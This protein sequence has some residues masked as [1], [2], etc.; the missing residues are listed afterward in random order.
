MGIGDTVWLVGHTFAEGF[1]PPLPFGCACGPSQFPFLI[2]HR[3][4]KR[5]R[6][7]KANFKSGG[8]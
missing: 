4:E 2:C 3:G 8:R 7:R 1:P 5:R 6:K